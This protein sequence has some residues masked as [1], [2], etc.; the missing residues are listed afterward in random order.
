MS[1][2]GSLFALVD[3]QARGVIPADNIWLAASAGT[4]KTQ[5]LTGRV[6]RLLLD[7]V[8]PSQILGLTFTKAGAAEMAQ[9]VRTILA[10]W[11]QL[12]E[13]DLV[14]Q[15]FAIGGDHLDSDVHRRARTLFAKVI[16]APGQGLAFQTIHSFCQSLLAAF[17]LE[18][19]LAPGFR[20]VDEAEAALL[21]RDLLATLADDAER[22]GDVP[23]LRD[24]AALSER[25]GEADALRWLDRCAD[26]S[27]A[28]LALPPAIAPYLREAF[29]LPV[30]DPYDW[31]VR[32][33][34]GDVDEA[35]W[36][37]IEAEYIAW[38]TTTG[39]K[40]ATII[41]AWITANRE[42]RADDL[43][44]LLTTIYTTEGTLRS[45]FGTDKQ[46]KP[47]KL[48]AV[49]DLAVSC[50]EAARE[51]LHTAAAMAA[52]DRYASALSA[53]RR[54][55]GAWATRK[56]RAGLVD[57]NDLI[58]QAMTL[59]DGEG[60]ADWIRYKLDQRID[61]ILVDEAQD[62]NVAQWTIIKR[63][64]EE[65]YAGEGVRD[66]EA[67]TL[68]V[69]GDYKQAIFGFQGT[70]PANFSAAEAWFR[71]RGAAAERPFAR[72]SIDT[73]YRSAPAIL[74]AVDAVANHLGSQQFGLAA[75]E[76]IRHRA[77]AGNT[78]GSVT[79][80]PW[81][82]A[83]S[84]IADGEGSEHLAEEGWIDDAT[85]RIADRIAQ[86]VQHWVGQGFDGS[87]VLPGDI[88]VLV[89]K[90][91]ELA[92]LI[93]ARLQARG[94]PVAGVD[95]LS[96][97]RPLA[98]QDL[99]AAARFA[100]QPLDDLNLASLLVSPLGDFC[101]DDLW[102]FGVGRG[103]MPLWP[104]LRGQAELAKR[105]EAL[106]SMLAMADY[107]SPYVFFETILSGPM[108]GRA[109]ILARMGNA[110]RDPIEELL[111]QAL[112]FGR[113]EGPSLHR[114]LRWFDSRDNEI[115][116]ETDIAG[117]E[118]RVMTVH[119]AKGLEARF[120]I[121]ADA[122][123]DPD[124]KRATGYHWAT[125]KGLKMPV[126]GFKKEEQPALLSAAQAEQDARD[127]EE[128]WRLLYVAM[129]R[130]KEGLFVTGALGKREEQPAQ[131]SWYT[132]I[133][134]AL[135]QLNARD[136][137]DPVWTSA[138]S[139]ALRRD[140]RRD[141]KVKHEAATAP[142]KP[143][144]IHS[145]PPDDPRPARPLRPSGLAETAAL[146]VSTPPLADNVAARR[147]TLIH[148][149]F[150]RLP[151]VAPTRRRDV[152]LAW[153]AGQA[154]DLSAALRQDMV[155]AAMLVLD[156]PRHAALFGPDA[157]AEVPLSAL[158]EGRVIAGA[159]DR[160]LVTEDMV[161][162]VDFKTGGQVPMDA[163]AVPVGYLRQMAAYHAAL[164]VIFPGRRVDAALLFTSGPL[165][166]TLPDA[167]LE[168]HRPAE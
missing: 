75:E 2:T 71:Q 132:A 126:V 29:G 20:A 96:L 115:K 168:A 107:V 60:S 104:Y 13:S 65:F 152:A 133:A 102:R 159:V 84:D 94:V 86:Q 5:V 117:G 135:D 72:L 162:V 3:D 32:W 90:R 27:E 113:D 50:G 14:D 150:E 57:F 134:A 34:A 28:L 101:Q 35:G 125:A 58:A 8:A 91:K 43:P 70:D 97:D 74:D 38:G 36:R 66:P 130:A 120:V 55:A 42:I 124:S 78:G 73:S 138:R 12:K 151:A 17:P 16:D 167:L 144:W 106:R 99:L 122:A 59:L 103:R 76:V 79:L 148:A 110:A 7:N 22:H 24:M 161:M 121:L 128:H 56:R 6:L 39:T 154:S 158:V 53:G 82:N 10:E 15:I 157:L 98:V 108:Q 4:G 140:R 147:G 93:V 129:T 25:L 92:S 64:A 18:A 23:F 67:R 63:L 155:D 136:S 145:L 54:F 30:S 118:A 44:K 61:H 77:A 166:I 105:L 114:F 127:R 47:N 69:V 21:R 89:R 19:G 156:D 141:K 165:L 52:S 51:A 33:C 137:A 62:T 11:V 164:R 88:L 37:D 95:R 68:F 46:G 81:E 100:I 1:G 41:R 109:K 131:S 143:A 85:R 31:L 45:F 40:M 149:L 163:K 87:E 139:Y 49:A 146:A 111:T 26:A 83:T 153:L 123:G 9:R 119:G 116:R 80:W 48:I 142:A 160:L 112:S